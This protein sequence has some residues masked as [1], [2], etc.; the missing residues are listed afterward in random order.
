MPKTN[1]LEL[2]PENIPQSSNAKRRSINWHIRNTIRKKEQTAKN[3]WIM[4]VLKLSQLEL[5]I[6]SI[7]YDLNISSLV[8]Y[9]ETSRA[10]FLATW[11]ATLHGV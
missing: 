10:N 11:F 2:L 4:F 3:D 1:H 7:T 5:N 6:C 8:P 9:L